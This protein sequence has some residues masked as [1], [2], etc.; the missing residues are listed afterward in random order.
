[1]QLLNKLPDRDFA[2]L[3]IDSLSEDKFGVFTHCPLD[4]VKDL[5]ESLDSFLNVPRSFKVRETK[6]DLLKQ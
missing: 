4:S 3:M 1:M 6:L 2:S 5:S